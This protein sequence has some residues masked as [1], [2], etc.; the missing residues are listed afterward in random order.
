MEGWHLVH[1]DEFLLVVEK[2]AGRLAVPGRGE[3]GQHNLTALVQAQFVDALVVH[4]LDMATSG[5]MLFARGAAVQSALNRAFAYR[6]MNKRYE[7]VVEGDVQGE[8]GSI[9]ARLAADWPQRPRQ[10]VDAEHG[11]PALTHW[12]VLQRGTGPE[13]C[14]TRL[15]LEPF[16]GRSHQLRVHLLSIGHPIV[17]D[18][19]YGHDPGPGGR[20]L[21][22]A[23]ALAFVHPGS[24]QPCEFKSAA[25]F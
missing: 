22:H 12:R 11:K 3:A 24:G 17:G 21:L 8:A 25:P 14:G 15:Q 23:C 7:A 9:H 20:L 5:L 18:A 10:K 6:R 19:L 16:T 1:E 2:P 13:R 4:R